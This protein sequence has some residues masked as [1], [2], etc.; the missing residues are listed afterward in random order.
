MKVAYSA[1]LW[2][3]NTFLT[4]LGNAGKGLMLELSRLFRAS[5]EGT[6]LVAI[7]LKACTVMSIT[8]LQKPFI[9]PEQKDNSTCLCRRL[10]I[11]K[12]GDIMSLLADVLNKNPYLGSF[13]RPVLGKVV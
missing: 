13:P 5:G 4:T 11:G 8:F 10:P 12:K 6:A 2:R 9:T 3:R 7:A 1:V